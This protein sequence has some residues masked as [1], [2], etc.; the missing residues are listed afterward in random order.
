MKPTCVF[1]LKEL[2]TIVPS[3]TTDHFKSE[4]PV[5]KKALEDMFHRLGCCIEGEIEI[6]EGVTSLNRFGI[7][8]TSPRFVVSERVDTEH[9]NSGYASDWAKR[10]S[11]DYE[12]IVDLGKLRNQR[13]Y[14]ANGNGE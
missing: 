4:N 7:E 3:I 5:V 10:Y 2:K 13:C 14:D 6:Q 11:T 1:T 12:M 8:D 9:L